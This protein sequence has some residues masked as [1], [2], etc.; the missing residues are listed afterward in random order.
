M[1]MKLS[2]YKGNGTTYDKFIDLFDK[3]L[4][5]EDLQNALFTARGERVMR[6]SFGTIIKDLLFDNWN[7]HVEETIKNDVRRVIS[8][9]PRI[10]LLELK[11]TPIEVGSVMSVNIELKINIIPLDEIVVKTFTI[12]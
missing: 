12:K 10:D 3:E 5:I 1:G 7:D 6:P 11:V 9:D 4:V 2:I 8:Y